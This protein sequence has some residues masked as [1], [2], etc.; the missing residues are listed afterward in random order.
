MATMRRRRN[1]ISQLRREDVTI[2]SDVEE[3]KGMAKDYYK[4]LYTSEGV[5][6]M[7][8]V[9][10]H[11]PTKFTGN[12]NVVLN[13]Q[14]SKEEVKVALFQMFPTKAPGPDGFP[15]HFYQRHWDLCGDEVTVVVLRIIRGEESPEGV[16]DTVIVLI[17]KG[18]SLT[19]LSQVKPISLCNE[20]YNKA[21]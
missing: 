13:K 18:A 2:C 12:M 16:N 4:K 8:E 15:A 19:H 7:V 6:G 9:L 11:I 1:R 10:S 5:I 17:P 14:Y 20:L 21:S 3:I